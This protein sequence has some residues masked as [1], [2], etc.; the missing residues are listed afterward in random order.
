MASIFAKEKTFYISSAVLKAVLPKEKNKN[1]S[2]Y[3]FFNKDELAFVLALG[4]ILY[5]Q[6]LEGEK[7]EV[8]SK[9]RR[10][11]LVFNQL[12][13][14][15]NNEGYPAIKTNLKSLITK[16]G[17][18][19]YKKENKQKFLAMIEA[20]KNRKVIISID[21]DG[22]D[23]SLVLNKIFLLKGVKSDGLFFINLPLEVNNLMKSK[24][25][26]LLKLLICVVRRIDSRRLRRA[27]KIKINAYKMLWEIGALEEVKK[28]KNQFLTKLKKNFEKLIKYEVIEGF[29]VPPIKSFDD[30]FLIDF[31]MTLQDRIIIKSKKRKTAK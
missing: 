21:R 15:G 4:E 9:R 11:N 2:N 29:L 17:F 16:S 7:I 26:F 22:E 1:N 28:Y 25:K 27:K 30:V 8:E 5:I 18:N 12:K 24:D 31:E 19:Y 20:F 23:L 14:R 13:G 3:N 10:G 6:S